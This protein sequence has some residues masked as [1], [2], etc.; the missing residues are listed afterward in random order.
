MKKGD[1]SVKMQVRGMSNMQNFALEIVNNRAI[2]DE[3]KIED[4]KVMTKET[5]HS[6]ARM[7]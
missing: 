6:D 7:P 2:F 3:A 5:F 1:N 4:V